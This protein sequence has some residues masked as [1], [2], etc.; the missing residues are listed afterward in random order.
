MTEDSS[1]AD[2]LAAV[3][4]GKKVHK[5]SPAFQK[6]WTNAE[7]ESMSEFVHKTGQEHRDR[8]NQGPPEIPAVDYKNRPLKGGKDGLLNWVN[9]V[10]LN[11]RF[12]YNHLI[13]RGGRLRPGGRTNRQLWKEVSRI[14]LAEFKYWSLKLKQNRQLMAQG[15]GHMVEYPKVSDL[16]FRD[17]SV[18]LGGEWSHFSC[19]WDEFIDL[20]K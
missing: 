5:L 9:S 3:F 11:R 15:R 19:F 13:Q 10:R 17:N 18:F 16:P 4:S 8:Q 20:M 1:K 6:D 2:I 7:I 14:L 12:K